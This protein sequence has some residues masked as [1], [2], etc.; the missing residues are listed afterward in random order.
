M[1]LNLLVKPIGIVVE[2]LV[3]NRIG[4][5]AFGLFSA[6]FSLATI[7]AVLSDLGISQLATKKIAA[8]KSYFEAYFPTVFPVKILLALLFPILMTGLGFVLGYDA[9]ALYLLF[10]I[11]FTFGLSQF[12]LFFR[13]TLQGNQ[14]FNVD[15][16]G[17]VADKFLLV[18]FVLALLP[19]GL[20]LEN[21]V[22][23][24]T[25]ATG[26]AFIALYYLIT[27]L[28]GRLRIKLNRAHLKE[29]LR[30]SLPFAL[31]TLV[32]GINERVDIV[33]LERL[34]SAKEAGL[35]AGP[36]R[37]V[38]AV[39]MYLWTILPIFFAK[40]ALTVQDKNEQEKLLHFGQVVVSLPIIFICV[41]S[42][43]YGELFF[44]QFSNSTA[45]EIAAMVQNLQIL[46]LNVLVHGFFAIYS[47]LLTSSNFEKPV[48]KLVAAS[49]I[50]NLTLNFIFIPE[51]GSL[52]AAWNT[53]FCA[54]FV[55]VGYFMMVGRM[56][57][58]KLPYALLLK[59]VLLAVLLGWLFFGL[60]LLSGLWWL[61]TIMAGAAFLV[62]VF[63]LQIIS[64]A[65]IRQ[66][67]NRRP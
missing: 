37:W 12:I 67:K 3:Q 39:M 42:F 16:V 58:I 52:A 7:G 36:Y 66:L 8:D 1:L 43:F 19:I 41:F 29:L 20:S 14:N 18:F 21:F 15:A 61:N 63:I 65:Q 30:D 44:F 49:I 33:M 62:L 11:A 5:E 53:L 27:K 56:V 47:T 6:L 46:F 31:I 23:A 4:H 60:D 48:S 45:A 32:Y 13:A 40:F 51:F 35:Y 64:L 24:R 50:L 34:S 9:H 38:D 57:K 28:Y 2:N 25:L 22:Y 17:S 26:L 10:F 55:S 54:V 59:L